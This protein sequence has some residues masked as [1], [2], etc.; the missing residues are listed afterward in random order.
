M[1]RGEDPAASTRLGMLLAAAD[2][3]LARQFRLAGFNTEQP[4]A[5]AQIA[6]ATVHSLTLRARAGAP[7][8]E[9]QQLSEAAITILCD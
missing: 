3:S 2:E 5:R 8:A 6:A 7:K 4:R 1:Q 9:L